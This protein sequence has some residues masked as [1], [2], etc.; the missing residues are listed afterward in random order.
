MKARVAALLLAFLGQGAI[1]EELVIS[2]RVLDTAKTKTNEDKPIS[3]ARVEL[4]DKKGNAIKQTVTQTNGLFHMPFE[5]EK[6]VKPNQTLR[7][8]ASGYSA[9]PTTMQVKLK[10]DAGTKIAYQEDV[11]L[12]NDKAIREDAA[13]LE[14]VAMAASQAQTTPVQAERARAIYASVSALPEGSKE[15]AFGTIQARSPSAFS[16]LMRVDREL[17]RTKQ[18]GDELKQQ[19]SSV[20]PAYDPAGRI[21][22]TGPAASK[23][24]MDSILKQAGKKGFEGQSVINDMHYGKQ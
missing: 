12:T 24:E 17:S 10:R 4:L 9:H 7:I 8:R 6:D 20:V 1:A 2:G 11:L 19:G 14:A 23:S 15:L 22:F 3:M 5:S 21:R 18:L 13:Y 16:E